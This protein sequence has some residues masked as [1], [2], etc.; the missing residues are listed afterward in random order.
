[1]SRKYVGH[2]ALGNMEPATRSAFL[3]LSRAVRSLSQTQR[4]YPLP[5][6]QEVARSPGVQQQRGFSTGGRST[7][8]IF[9]NDVD[10]PTTTFLLARG[11]GAFLYVAQDVD[12]VYMWNG[13]AYKSATFS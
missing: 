1:M 2:R 10:K 8:V 5:N 11:T 7:P 12:K 9:G 4:S 13:A 3:N 6:E